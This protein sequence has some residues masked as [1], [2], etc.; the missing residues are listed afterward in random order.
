MYSLR[1]YQTDLINKIINS[2]KSGHRKIIVQSPPR[3]G[4]TVVMA[5]IARRTTENKNCVM[6]L[7]HRKEVL[8]QARN[9]FFQQNVDFNY[10]TAGMVQTLTRRVDKLKEPQLILI[11]E[12]HH[13]L[14]KS[15]QM[16]LNKFPNTFVLMFTATPVRTGK[17]QLDIVAD[18]LIVG[19]SIQELTDQGFLAPFDYYSIDDINSKKLKKSSTGDYTTSSMDQAVSKKIYGHIV[20]NYEKLAKGMQ[21]VVFT[22]SI[23]SAK[24]IASEFNA[25]GYSAVEL[26]GSTDKNKREKIVQNFRDKKTTILVNVNLF[27]EGVDLPDVD[28]VIMARPTQSLA[29]YLQFSMRCLNPREGK[30]AIIIDHVANWKTFGLPNSDRDWKNA[31]ITTDKRD[32][33][34]KN[35]V[36]QG[37]QITQCDYCFAVVEVKSIKDGKCPMCGN[38]IKVHD[39]LKETND[40]LIKIEQNHEVMKRKEL[41]NKMINNDL[42]KIVAKKTLSELTTLKELQIYA[43]LHGYKPGWAWH[44]AKRRGLIKNDREKR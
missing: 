15:Y 26:D 33:K 29:L 5:E 4:K 44:Q 41:V 7:I 39:P 18:D 34:L 10:L 38:P 27:T 2:M 30:R 23:E 28:C 19:Q 6:F 3:T 14:A 25:A 36:P 12:A 1:P 31:I 37:P 20:E 40:K 8:E 13:V 17:K 22:Y 32:K 9:T 35:T 11:D 42:Y 21:A 24:K 43:K 16:I